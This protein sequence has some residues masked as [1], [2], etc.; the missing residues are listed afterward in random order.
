MIDHARLQRA[1]VAFMKEVG[2]SE[3]I[4]ELRRELNEE[5]QAYNDL[6]KILLERNE[7]HHQVWV[8]NDRLRRQNEILRNEVKRLGGDA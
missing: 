8:E 3:A 6:N 1:A 2:E 7:T 4:T 5:R